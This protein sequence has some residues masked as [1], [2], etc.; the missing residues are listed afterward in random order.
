MHQNISAKEDGQESEPLYDP[1]AAAAVQ[2]CIDRD[3]Q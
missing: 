1:T 2:N 3:Y